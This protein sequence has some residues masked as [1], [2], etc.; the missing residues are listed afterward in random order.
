MRRA[1]V[2]MLLAILS[3]TDSRSPW[4]S[5]SSC[6]RPP[7]CQVPLGVLLGGGRR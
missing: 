4:I 5:L 2:P 1:M 3:L 6:S 7:D